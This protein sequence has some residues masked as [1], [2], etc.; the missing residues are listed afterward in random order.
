[1]SETE[2]LDRR[3]AEMITAHLT[4]DKQ[5]VI[6]L[7]DELPGSMLRPALVLL[8]GVQG[9]QLAT[10]LETQQRQSLAS[11]ADQTMDD[12]RWVGERPDERGG[13]S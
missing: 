10:G 6:R 4:G 12:Q 7:V 2:S 3:L 13:L 11:S 8:V 5:G 9:D 1:M